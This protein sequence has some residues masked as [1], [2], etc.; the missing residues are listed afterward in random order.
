LFAQL[1]QDIRRSRLKA[2]V[3]TQSLADGRFGKAREH[4]G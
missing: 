2:A 4:C 3:F 1:T